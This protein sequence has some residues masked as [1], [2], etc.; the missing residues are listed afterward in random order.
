MCAGVCAAVGGC[1]TCLRVYKEVRGHPGMLFFKFF[2]NFVWGRVSQWLGT[3]PNRLVLL[4]SE[5]QGFSCLCFLSCLSWDHETTSQALAFCV[6]SEDLNS[7]PKAC[8]AFFCTVPLS[9]PKNVIFYIFLI[10]NCLNGLN[11]SLCCC[12]CM[13]DVVGRVSP[14]VRHLPLHGLK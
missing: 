1:I 12:Y 9:Q 3:S 10:Q 13:S 11:C 2:P 8:K 6:D 7:G 14:R 4:V 5:L